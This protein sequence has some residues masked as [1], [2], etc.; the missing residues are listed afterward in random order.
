MCSYYVQLVQNKMLISLHQNIQVI[1][2]KDFKI[3]QENKCF[4]VKYL[5]FE[6]GFS[7]FSSDEKT[8][9]TAPYE[10]YYWTYNEYQKLV[11]AVSHCED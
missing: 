9:A 7:K 2:E 3:D 4:E 11:R 5:V 10:S 1:S 8:S 6:K